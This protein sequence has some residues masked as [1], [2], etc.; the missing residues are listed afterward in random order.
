M[1]RRSARSARSRAAD[2]PVQVFSDVKLDW[3]AGTTRMSAKGAGNERTWN[4]R[5]TR[6]RPGHRGPA[7]R[8]RRRSGPQHA[9]TSPSPSAAAATPTPTAAV[10]TT[11][12]PT[13]SVVVTSDLAYESANAPLDA[14]R[15]STSMRRPRPVRGPWSSC[16]TAAR[17]ARGPGPSTPARWRTSASSSSLRRGAPAR[18]PPRRRTTKPGVPVP[19]RLCGRLRPGARGRV[20]RRPGHDDR[21]R[22]LGGRQHS[23]AG[24]LR[25]ARADGGL[26]RGPTLGPIDALVT[27][28][29]DWVLATTSWAG[30]NS[31]PPTPGS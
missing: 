3:R 2:R 28:E 26:P 15:C 17:T 18:W 30:T 23:G 12:A 21:L 4:G 19:G 24:R 13:P 20:W 29:G 14:G 6:G 7:G 16:S 27:W 22:P 1:T 10:T 8:L 9:P 11:P 25:P 31:S 5:P